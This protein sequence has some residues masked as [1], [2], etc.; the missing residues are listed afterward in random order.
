M[1]F[2]KPGVYAAFDEGW[3]TLRIDQVEAYLDMKK[4]MM[5]TMF[6]MGG[7]E[8]PKYGKITGESKS[9]KVKYLF[10]IELATDVVYMQL[11]DKLFHQVLYVP[12][13]PS[14]SSMK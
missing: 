5:T 9:T 10:K 12:E 8:P 13:A 7:C 1:S 14:P 3:L 11:G 4:K 2:I 6:T